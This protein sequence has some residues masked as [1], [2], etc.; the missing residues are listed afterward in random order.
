VRV[1]VVDDGTGAAYEKHRH[2]ASGYAV[3]GVAAVATV[4]DG[5]CVNARVAVGG[6]T[7]TPVRATDAEQVMI[8]IAPVDQGRIGAAAEEVPTA[9]TGALADTYASSEYRMH[10]A[11]VLAKRAIEAALATA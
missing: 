10:L 7:G 2:P 11:Q 1:P 3:A 8:G 9:L 5:K 6:V 4:A